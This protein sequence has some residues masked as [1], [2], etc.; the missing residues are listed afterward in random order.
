MLFRSRL[1]T[2]SHTRTALAQRERKTAQRVYTCVADC[3]AYLFDS[4]A[5]ILSARGVS[6]LPMMTSTSCIFPTLQNWGS[7]R[8]FSSPGLSRTV[9]DL[10]NVPS[11]SPRVVRSDVHFL[12][13]R[14][15]RNPILAR[16]SSLTS[17][18][19]HYISCPRV[20]TGCQLKDVTHLFMPCRFLSML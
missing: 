6:Y 14:H 9:Y 18:Q 11:I 20:R 1:Q 12:M 4:S 3:S 13:S 15:H 19:C 17:R 2:K 8:S 7:S 5:A 16:D 10:V